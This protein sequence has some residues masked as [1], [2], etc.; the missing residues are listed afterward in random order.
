GWRAATAG[1][2]MPVRELGLLG[3][4]AA[5]LFAWLAADDRVPRERPH[6]SAPAERLFPSRALWLLFL[7]ASIAFSL[8]DFTGWSMGTLGSLFLQKAHQFDLKST[9]LAL[10]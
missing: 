7:A 10:S 8:R 2:R 3:I 5:L 6:N 4:F 9:G 1:W